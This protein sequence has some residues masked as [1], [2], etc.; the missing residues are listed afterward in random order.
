MLRL[1][2]RPDKQCQVLSCSRFL[3][4]KIKLESLFV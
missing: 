3:C 2:P 4:P 1:Y